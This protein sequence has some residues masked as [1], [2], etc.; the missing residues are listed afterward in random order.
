MKIADSDLNVEA[1][2]EALDI[3]TVE[4]RGSWHDCLCPLHQENNPSFS[5][6]LENGG[7]I[8]RHGE[9]TGQLVSLVMRLKEI[10]RHEALRWMIDVAPRQ[11]H[12]IDDLLERLTGGVKLEEHDPLVWAKSYLELQTNEMAEYWFERG[13][14][15][16]TM[17][18][19]GV[20]YDSGWPSPHLIWPVKDDD[21]NT[22]SFIL[23]YLESNRASKYMNPKG[24]ERTLFPL[25]HFEGDE[26]ILV[27]GPLDAMWLHQH[28]H[29]GALAMLGSGVT[30]KQES[31]LRGH[32][33]KITLA[34]DNDVEGRRG[35]DNLLARLR[36]FDLRVAKIP[37]P[38]KD[39]QEVA[40]KD[41]KEMLKLA[42]T[43]AEFML[44]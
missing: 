10:P 39:V 42:K 35:T 29:H 40:E 18:S 9:D 28:G 8:C 38:A 12:S 24:F 5:V 6:N 11:D 30:V 26:A 27:E 20:K 2:L 16:E 33:T 36:S 34:L 19:F 15:E 17:H 13:F 7:W 21:G 32:V 31:W 43:G 3:K 37:S 22:I 44:G 14:T 23:R 25:D 41:L 4:S 1:V